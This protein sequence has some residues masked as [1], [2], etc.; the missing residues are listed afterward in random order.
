MCKPATC[1]TCGKKS[2]WGCGNH[3]AAVMS[4]QDESTWCTCTPRVERDGRHF[5]PMAA[6][7]DS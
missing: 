7:A 4:A 2:W 5:P 6:Q 1:K 3:V